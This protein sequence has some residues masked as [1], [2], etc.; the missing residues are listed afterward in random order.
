MCTI[1][2]GWVK[3]TWYP[4]M[5]VDILTNTLKR[6]QEREIPRWN[7]YTVRIGAC[8]AILR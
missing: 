1:H 8:I 4:S 6:D 3:M 5:T 2:T 7:V